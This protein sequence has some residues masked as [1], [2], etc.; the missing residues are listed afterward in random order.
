[1]STNSRAQKNHNIA[2]ILKLKSHKSLTYD[3]VS[4][5]VVQK[6]NM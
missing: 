3:T 2:Q 5:N 1:M 4:Y 6:L